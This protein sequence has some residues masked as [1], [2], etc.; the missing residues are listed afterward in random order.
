MFPNKTRPTGFSNGNF[1]S[2]V[3]RK[4]VSLQDG[5]PIEA[6]R[7]YR[8]VSNV[9]PDWHL[10]EWMKLRGKRQTDL[11]RELG[12]VK[13]RANKYFHGHHPYRREIVNEL[14]NWLEIEPY[15][16]LMTPAE[17]LRLRRLRD[18]AIEIA[19][20]QPELQVRSTT[21]RTVAERP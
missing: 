16:L 6:A 3:S 7:H 2:I 12:W 10:K 17:A 11:V 14:S 4:E 15:E 19:A 21:E 9:E 5:D 13:G 18:A 8:P 1:E 20:A